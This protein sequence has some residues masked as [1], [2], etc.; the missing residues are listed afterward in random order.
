MFISSG[1]VLVGF[2]SSVSVS[3]NSAPTV[4]VTVNMST[5]NCPVGFPF[6]LEFS[7][8]NG[9]AGFTIE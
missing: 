8:S 1:S 7:T 6:E 3:E 4:C 5:S 2:D 9:T